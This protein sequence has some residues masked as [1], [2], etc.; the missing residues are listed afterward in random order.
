[1]CVSH[2]TDRIIGKSAATAG[3][4]KQRESGDFKMR[5]CFLPNILLPPRDKGR[6]KKSLLDLNSSHT[7]AKTL[8]SLSSNHFNIILCRSWKGRRRFFS[9]RYPM[10]SSNPLKRTKKKEEKKTH[11]AQSPQPPAPPFETP[12]SCIPEVRHV[13]GFIWHKSRALTVCAPLGVILLNCTLN[14]YQLHIDWVTR[15]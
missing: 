11:S 7:L 5:M 2:V 6:E 4:P 14:K 3:N 12:S 10:M 13:L 1:M 15:D 9:L 8:V